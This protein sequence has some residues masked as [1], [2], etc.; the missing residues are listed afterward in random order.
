MET[1]V[2]KHVT[3]GSAANQNRFIVTSSV[4]LFKVRIP[5]I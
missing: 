2:G 5:R 3:C 1:D 4:S